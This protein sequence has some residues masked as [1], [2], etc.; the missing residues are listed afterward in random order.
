M[1]PL[2]VNEQLVRLSAD[3]STAGRQFGFD[4][5]ADAVRVELPAQVQLVSL[6]LITR[7]NLEQSHEK[8]QHRTIIKLNATWPTAYI[9]V[10]FG[11]GAVTKWGALAFADQL[12][13]VCIT[14]RELEHCKNKEYSCRRDT[15]QARLCDLFRRLSV[16]S[17]KANI[18]NLRPHNRFSERPGP[19]CPGYHRRF[20]RACPHRNRP[21]KPQLPL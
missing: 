14:E 9:V 11:F 21:M 19:I 7:A 5:V 13:D 15:R 16:S 4:L 17:Q 3:P 12:L 2:L 18:P 10:Q 6:E 20:H 8:Q 1:R